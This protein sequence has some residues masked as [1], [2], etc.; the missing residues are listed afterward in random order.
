M[1]INYRVFFIIL[2]LILQILNC[3][4][5]NKVLFYRPVERAD[6]DIIGGRA[7]LIRTVYCDIYIE[8]VDSGSWNYLKNFNMFKGSGKGNPVDPCFHFII[9]NTW[10]KPFIIEK[11][12]AAYN[13]E[14]IPVEDYSFIKD[15][16]YLGNRYSV[17]ISSL[18]KKRRILSDKNLLGEIDFENETAGYRLNFIAPGDK[19]SFFSFFQRISSGK[20][21]KIRVIIKYFDVKKVIDFDIG[22]FEYNEIENMQQ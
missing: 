9:V 18:L 8:Y 20:S 7:G 3:S 22:R 21:S 19:V 12:E 4:R 17:N 14:I 2:F 10:N 1:N 5:E 15:K 6:I 16:S 11:V 13:G